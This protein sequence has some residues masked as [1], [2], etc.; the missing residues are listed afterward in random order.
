[1]KFS[2]RLRAI[3]F[4]IF[5]W[6][7]ENTNSSVFYLTVYT[8]LLRFIRLRT[9]NEVGT[10]FALTLSNAQRCFSCSL[11]ARR[12]S[13]RDENIKRASRKFCWT[14]KDQSYTWH[15]LCALPTSTLTHRASK[16]P[17]TI[18]IFISFISRSRQ[19]FGR[20]IWTWY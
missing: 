5:R 8:R 18:F 15:I 9:L 19:T 6:I 2:F 4:D 17:S 1:M 12:F 7:V 3:Y 20:N 16:I 10:R 11:R 14:R 13:G